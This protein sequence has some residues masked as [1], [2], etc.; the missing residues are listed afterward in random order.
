MRKLK[1]FIYGF[2]VYFYSVKYF[3]LFTISV[4][5][6]SCDNL[7]KKKVSSETIL[8]EQLQTFNWNDV[9]VFPAFSNCDE[10]A[11]KEKRKQCF[12]ETLSEFIFKE[13]HEAEIVAS[14]SINETVTIDFQISETGILTVLDI[15]ESDILKQEIPEFESIIRNALEALPKIYPA[16][17]R[18]QQVKTQFKLPIVISVE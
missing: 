4:L 8:E 12:Q 14:Q 7:V 10:T 17:K 15:A 13:I 11:S 5:L 3:V 1:L 2:L 6:F 18:G 16:T 9:D